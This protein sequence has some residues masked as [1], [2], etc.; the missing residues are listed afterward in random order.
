MQCEFYLESGNTLS[1]LVMPL[2][3]RE[4]KEVEI[5]LHDLPKREERATRIRMELAMESEDGVS[6]TLEDLG[7]G[8]I[9]PATHRIWHERLLL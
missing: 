1:I 3:G 9:Y 4:S 8:E 2:T 7:F 6:V 5:I